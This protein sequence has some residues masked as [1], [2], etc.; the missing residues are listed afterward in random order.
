MPNYITY[1][2]DTEEDF[3]HP[4]VIMWLWQTAILK[5]P[6]DKKDF[7]LMVDTNHRE[8]AHFIGW[9]IE[10]P[11][12]VMCHIGEVDLA[13]VKSEMKH[14]VGDP[15]PEQF[16]NMLIIRMVD[17]IGSGIPLYLHHEVDALRDRHQE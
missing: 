14:C 16:G 9:M 6:E 10:A 8:V 3:L 7:L 4:A 13:V 15:C 11:M 12:V 17:G 5:A 1:S 2:R